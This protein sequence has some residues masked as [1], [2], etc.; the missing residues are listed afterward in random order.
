MTRDRVAYIVKN[1]SV[2]V[3]SEFFKASFSLRLQF[4][5]H[6]PGPRDLE[7][8]KA[9]FVTQKIRRGEVAHMKTKWWH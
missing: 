4:R 3:D 1:V 2:L 8:P 5:C 9:S 7:S 6:F